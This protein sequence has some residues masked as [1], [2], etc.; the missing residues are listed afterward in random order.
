MARK[1]RKIRKQ[2]GAARTKE[3]Q[4]K[5]DAKIWILLKK[6]HNFK[7]KPLN[8]L[9]EN[10]GIYKEF[11][12]TKLKPGTI[13]AFRSKEPV[14]KI[15]DRPMWLDYSPLIQKQSFL[16]AVKN[17]ENLPEEIPLLMAQKFGPWINVV[18]II[19]PITILHF[20]VDYESREKSQNEHSFSSFFEGPIHALCAK[21]KYKEENFTEECADGYTLDFFFHE[22]KGKFKG[23]GWYPGYRE[24]CIYHPNESVEIVEFIY[25]PVPLPAAD[26]S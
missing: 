23:K 5:I 2:K 22:M 3:E 26:P 7:E 25:D 12:K 20:P 9:D 18:R 11:K 16:R 15:E 14:A 1:T 19:K 21:K 10:D 17:K 24:I 13:L 6:M 4:Q 8:T